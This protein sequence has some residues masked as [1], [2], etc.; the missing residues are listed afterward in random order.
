MPDT[1]PP[2]TR[3]KDYSPPPYL[4]DEVALRFELD[5]DST[6]VCSRLQI[7]RNP[8]VP[9]GK[10]HIVLDGVG[11]ALDAAA[12]D[13]ESLARSHYVIDDQTLRIHAVPDYFTLE[14]ETRLRPH[15]MASLLL[16]PTT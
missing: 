6:R 11:L 8:D 2:T 12:L 10:C 14:L 16:G 3:L 15:S 13:G 5:E 7:R 9:D 1:T 4:V